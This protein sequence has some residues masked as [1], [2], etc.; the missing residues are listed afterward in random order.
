[1]SL[2]EKKSRVS[3]SKLITWMKHPKISGIGDSQSVRTIASVLTSYIT[4]KYT[5]FQTNI[6]VLL[7]GLT[8]S[9]EIVDI[10][11]NEGLGISYNDVLMLQDFCVVNDRKRSV[12]CPFQIA[13]GKPAILV[14]TDT[15]I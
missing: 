7:H 14:P 9:R 11:H 3:S 15:M 4:G 5:A 6:S 13:K 2:K 8:K 1:M 12:N 10:M